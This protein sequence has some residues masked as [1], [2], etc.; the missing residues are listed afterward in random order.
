MDPEDVA[1]IILLLLVLLVF[2]GLAILWMAMTNRRAIREMEHRER[3]AMIQ[4]GLIPAPELDPLG[5]DEAMGER[6]TASTASDRWRTAGVTFIGLGLG[7]MMLIGF[8]AGEP[9]IGLGIGGG[10]AILG[11]TLVLNGLQTRRPDV[12][13]YRPTPHAPQRPTRPAPP[14][15]PEPPIQ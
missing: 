5:F 13:R 4:Q 3:V 8:A 7:L 2:A 11:A 12:S 9:G 15:P 10:F 6:S 14:P 1:L